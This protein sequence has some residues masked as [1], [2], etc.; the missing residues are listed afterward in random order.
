MD[1]LEAYTFMSESAMN[2]CIRDNNDKYSVMNGDLF[3][4]NGSFTE[5]AIVPV[6]SLNKSTWQKVTK[7]KVIEFYECVLTYE[8]GTQELKMVT[9]DY[10]YKK[11]KKCITWTG[12]TRKVEIPDE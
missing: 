9:D 6:H 5:L 1:F 12:K 4:Y 10:L 3:F 2:A 8:N 11:E 7:K